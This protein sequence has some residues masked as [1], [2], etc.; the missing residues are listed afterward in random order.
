ML[1]TMLLHAIETRKQITVYKM[2]TVIF[3]HVID[4]LLVVCS[5]SFCSNHNNTYFIAYLE[6]K[7]PLWAQTYTLR[8][9]ILMKDRNGLKVL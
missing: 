5:E 1:Y 6:H 9:I 8:G 4:A 3:H 7:V 2:Y